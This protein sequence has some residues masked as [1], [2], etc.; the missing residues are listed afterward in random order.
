MWKRYVEYRHQG[1][2]GDENAPGVGN[3]GKC[4][5]MAQKPAFPYRR[6]SISIGQG[7]S[8]NLRARR[9]SRTSINLKEQI[10]SSK[11]LFSKSSTS[12]LPNEELDQLCNQCLNLLRQNKI[13]SKNAFEILLI[14]HL[15]EIVNAQNSRRSLG[16]SEEGGVQAAG[17]RNVKDGSGEKRMALGVSQVKGAESPSALELAAA[18]DSNF[19]KFQRAAVT[20]EASARIYG[21]RVDS[22]FDNAY[23]I[24][25]NIK[26]GQAMARDDSDL[27]MESADG[28][29]REEGDGETKAEAKAEAD[30][31]KRSWRNVIFPGEGS[32][33]VDSHECI[34]IKDF[35]QTKE[36]N[37]G[38]F[39]VN[40]LNDEIKLDSIRFGVDCNNIGSISSMMMNNLDLRDQTNTEDGSVSISYNISG[41]T[42]LSEKQDSLCSW[43]SRDEQLKVD[44]VALAQLLGEAGGELAESL[45]GPVCPDLTRLVDSIEAIS[46]KLV[47]AGQIQDCISLRTC[48]MELEFREAEEESGFPDPG[49][50][51]DSPGGPLETGGWEG[52]EILGLDAGARSFQMH[53][54]R[55][56]QDLGNCGQTG[57]ASDGV[58]GEVVEPGPRDFKLSSIGD[59]LDLLSSRST[60]NVEFLCGSRRR[61]RPPQSHRQRPKPGSEQ[62][63][64]EIPSAFLTSEVFDGMEWVGGL[65]RTRPTA[66]DSGKTR[67]RSRGKSSPVGGVFVGESNTSSI[68]NYSLGHLFCLANLT[69]IKMNLRSLH[70]G[71]DWE[72][73]SGEGSLSRE[74]LIRTVP[75]PEEGGMASACGQTDLMLVHGEIEHQMQ[76]SS[77]DIH[78]SGLD[79]FPLEDGGGGPAQGRL[80]LPFEEGGSETD[81]LLEKSSKSLHVRD[82]YNSSLRHSKSS[83][84]A[85]IDLVKGVLRSSIQTLQSQN[86]SSLT[87]FN[88]IRQSRK[89]LQQKG[90]SEVSTGI[91][92][93]CMLHLCNESNYS[94]GYL[95]SAPG[96][97]DGLQ[98]GGYDSVAQDLNPHQV[99]LSLDPSESLQ[100]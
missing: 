7:E 3:V 84:N 21:Y 1:R 59:V 100:R 48:S 64:F 74:L 55:V 51:S 46:Q 91:F 80:L 44:K 52:E 27:D 14:D 31:R 82:E 81:V 71:K 88:I 12:K 39:F 95:E 92:F 87:L 58:F 76:Q 22:T 32:T 16:G 61:E 41:K 2:H 77:T 85:D 47:D 6:R 43:P 35:D 18:Q 30:R 68:F 97:P 96:S 8:D 93:I 23:R 70:E 98:L 5:R 90:L 49:L 57:G 15:N 4:A 66:G 50:D 72:E 13:S 56:I 62:V 36:I 54:G 10:D 79:D 65:T 75:Q 37:E 99:V 45:W 19:Q 33:L 25:S 67:S 63:N 24:L 60:R 34:T 11:V 28:G 78:S 86:S 73:V 83:R 89:L 94:L 26:S 29:E 53:V 20:L 69:G 9:L 42:S 40:Y 17:Q 38:P